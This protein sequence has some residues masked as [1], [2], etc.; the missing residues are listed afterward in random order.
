MHNFKVTLSR[1]G[2]SIRVIGRCT[3]KTR[4]EEIFWFY[5]IYADKHFF[6]TEIF[7]NSINVFSITFKQCT[8][9]EKYYIILLFM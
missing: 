2:F 6:E 5:S 8:L 7:C 9:A 1:G 4:K 3:T